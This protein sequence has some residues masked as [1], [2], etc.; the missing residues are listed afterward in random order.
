MKVT[1]SHELT[2]K[3]EENSKFIKEKGV[4]AVAELG[5][6]EQLEK[7]TILGKEGLNKVKNHNISNVMVQEFAA[8]EIEAK[9]T[10][11]AIEKKTKGNRL[12]S[13]AAFAFAWKLA[14]SQLQ[15]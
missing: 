3:N 2:A 10:S 14:Q 15:V 13:S 8:K 7:R 6:K 11:V 5:V 12:A 9:N 4:K 1:H